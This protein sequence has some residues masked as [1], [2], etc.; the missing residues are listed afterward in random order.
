MHCTFLEQ[1]LSYGN[2]AV[3]ESISLHFG[4]FSYQTWTVLSSLQG[5]VIFQGCWRYPDY[6]EIDSEW[7]AARAF[8]IIALIFGFAFLFLEMFAACQ[9]STR[10][11][12]RVAPSSG[13][14]FLFCSLSSGLTL[15]FLGSD[16]C[17]E[18]TLTESLEA[19]FPNINMDV[20]KCGISTGA[21]CTIAA[22]I[23]WFLAGIASCHAMKVENEIDTKNAGN[24]LQ[25]PLNP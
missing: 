2:S 18:N 17:K 8:A 23:L 14:G 20:A 13:T 16:I 21:N 12:K 15:L 19:V 24:G 5:A 11:G 4:L 1:V 3:P 9:G 10:G 22:T 25:E 7:K 6:V